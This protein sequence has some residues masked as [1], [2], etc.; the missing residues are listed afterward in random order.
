M[1]LGDPLAQ[2]HVADRRPV[3]DGARRGPSRTRA[4][5]PRAAP[6]RRRCRATAR[7]GRRRSVPCLAAYARPGRLTGC[8]LMSESA[9][10]ELHRAARAFATRPRARLP[11]ARLAPGSSRRSGRRLARNAGRPRPRRQAVPR[12]RRTAGT[13]SCT[14]TSTCATPP[15]DPAQPVDGHR[16]DPRRAP[17]SRSR[18][19]TSTSR[20]DSVGDVSG[21]TEAGRGSRRDGEE[22]VDGA[23]AARSAAAAPSSCRCGDFAAHADRRPIPRTVSTT[24]FFVT[25]DGTRDRRPAGRRRTT[26][27]PP[28][29]TR[30]TRP[31]SPSRF[32]VPAG[33]T[34]V[35][36]GVLIAKRTREGRTGWTLPPAPADG[37]RADPARGRRLRP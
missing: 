28:T 9:V 11:P 34:A 21:R 14:T 4:A 3:R 37:H 12:S 5:R 36:N 10:A 22:L 18:A 8:R 27:C 35:G 1:L 32:D 6:P 24:A 33:T 29:T 20:G 13:T 25:P 17:P 15:A 16:D 7:P 31:A 19:S 30:A 23:E 2:R 26:S